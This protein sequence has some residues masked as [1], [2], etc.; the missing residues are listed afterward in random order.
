MPLRSSLLSILLLIVANPLASASEAVGFAAPTVTRVTAI[1]PDLVAVYVVHGRLEDFAQEPYVEQPGDKVLSFKIHRWLERDGEAIGTLVGPEQDTLLRASQLDKAQFTAAVLDLPRLWSLSPTSGGETVGVDSVSRRSKPMDLVR[2]GMYEVGGPIEHRVILRTARPLD[3]SQSYVIDADLLGLELSEPGVNEFTLNKD[4]TN[5]AIHVSRVG[6]APRDPLKVGFVSLWLSD[7]SKLNLT[8]APAFSVVSVEDGEVVSRGRAELAYDKSESKGV[9]INSGDIWRLDF[10]D[11]TQPG[12]YVLRVA[13]LGQSQ[14]FDVED[15]VWQNAHRTSTRGLLHQRSGLALGP[16]HTEFTRPRP[17][18]PDD[19][20]I[21]LRSEAPFFAP[22]SS[23]D[24]GERFKR[25]RAAHTVGEAPNAWGGYMDAADFDR[26][27]HH[28]IASRLLLTL[29][30]RFPDYAAQLDLNLPTANDKLPDLIDEARWAIDFH[31]RM[32][33]GDGGISGGIESE[34][35]PRIGEASWQEG[36]AVYQFAPDPVSSALYA[37]SAAQLSRLMKSHDSAEA[38][39]YL[40]SA[41]LA[42]QYA[43][44]HGSDGYGHPFTDAV[45]LAALHL[46]AATGDDA[47]HE[48]FRETSAFHQPQGR[49]AKWKQYDQGEAAFAYLTLDLTQRDENLAKHARDAILKEADRLVKTGMT[50]GFGWTRDPA[51]K[52]GWGGLSSGRTLFPVVYAAHLEPDEPKYLESLLRSVQFMLGANPL[53]R[54]FTTGVGEASVRHVSH[55]DSR[56]TGQPLPPGLTTMGPMQPS[57]LRG[58]WMQQYVT[59]D[60]Y[61]AVDDWPVTELYFDAD[62]YHRNSEYTVH[63]TLSPTMFVLGNLAALPR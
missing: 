24:Q 14:P 57:M 16:P 38:R 39:D 2:V 52:I 36:L 44:A 46:F 25:L 13:G 49:T 5:E 30:D 63:R 19:G 1:A 29:A 15:G 9:G 26:Q 11:L 37:A 32:Q 60:V 41:L 12:R 22:D 56:V 21:V 23:N 31:R 54:S 61:P 33:D 34:D 59:A 8:D 55:I 53:N 7:N 4:R 51:V 50:T 62:L 20:F 3:V 48:R 43:D 28:L 45:N 40:D 17:M 47:W 6:F 10:S 27:V 42:M 58:Y 35:H 18:H